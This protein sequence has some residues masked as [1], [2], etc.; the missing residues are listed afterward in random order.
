MASASAPKHI[1]YLI[2]GLGMG[3]AERLMIPLLQHL[4]RARFLPRVAYLHARDG[5][6][7]LPDLHALHIPVDYLPVQHLRDLTALPRLRRYLQRHQADLVHTQLEFSNILGNLAAKTL[8]LPSVCTLHVLPSSESR[9][10]T[11]LHQHLEWLALRLFCDRVIAVSEQTREDYRARSGIPAYRLVTIY[12][13]IDLTPFTRL[14]PDLER[15]SVRSEFSLPPDVFLLITVAVLRPPKG[16]ESMIRALP[17]VLQAHPNTC[18][19]IV[20]DGPH[21]HALEQEVHTLGLTRQVIFAGMRRDIPR[22]LAASD[23]F[24]LPTLTEALPTVLAEAMAARLPILASAVGGIPE[25]VQDGLNGRLVT[26]GQPEDLA[27]AC[28]D[29][30]SNPQARQRMGQQGW[31]IVQTR[32]NIVTQVRQLETLYE[33]EWRRYGRSHPSGHG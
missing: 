32:F 25:M 14:Q 18:Y 5:N 2:D 8:H 28:I 4:D 17:A 15:A 9:L 1:I 26:P 3:G 16:I 10:K 21:R 7:L 29:L 24:I 22:L 23:L 31:Q 12:N 33:E 11:R 19:L 30:L 6:P 20:G 13:G 27:N